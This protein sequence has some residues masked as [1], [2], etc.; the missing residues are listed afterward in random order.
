MTVGQEQ[1]DKPSLHGA[2]GGGL[3]S[4]LTTGEVAQVL[5]KT[6]W[7]VCSYVRAGKLRAY[8]LG[9]EFRFTPQMVE[10]FLVLHEVG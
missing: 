9:H 7:A 1:V 5:K 2:P 8:R 3:A 10:S 4:L 6:P